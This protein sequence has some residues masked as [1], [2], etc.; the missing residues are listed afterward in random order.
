MH[1]RTLTHQQNWNIFVAE[2]GLIQKIF[3]LLQA[4]SSSSAYRPTACPSCLI[5]WRVGLLS[6]KH[7]NTALA[8]AIRCTRTSSGLLRERCVCV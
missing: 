5:T 3:I 8:L 7:Q 2:N 4:I 1:A 6:L